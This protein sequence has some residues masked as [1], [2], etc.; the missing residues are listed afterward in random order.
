MTVTVNFAGIN[1]NNLYRLGSVN[2]GESNLGGWSAHSKSNYGNGF[3]VGFNNTA[4]NFPRIIDNDLIDEPV[5]D[6]DNVPSLQNQ[7]V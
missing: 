2:I 3:F 7:S 1:I 5:I 6:M 4:N